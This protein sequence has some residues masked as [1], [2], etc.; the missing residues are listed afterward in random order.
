MFVFC[1]AIAV[2][3]LNPG[4][5]ETDKKHSLLGNK[6]EGNVLDEFPALYPETSKKKHER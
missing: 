5:V 3:L 2:C 4:K 6:L 1:M